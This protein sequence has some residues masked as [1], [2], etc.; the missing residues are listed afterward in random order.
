MI[1]LSHLKGQKLGVLG[2]GKSGLSTAKA[3]KKAGV[4]FIAWDDREEGR[5]ALKREVKIEAT[6]FT[7][8]AVQ[9]LDRLVLSPGIAHTY[10]EPNPAVALCKENNVRIISDVTLFLE[11]HPDNP[12]YAITGTNGKSTTTALL[13]HIFKGVGEVLVGGNIGE[14][15]LELTPPK[16]KDVPFVLE[17]SSYQLEITPNLRPRVAVLL[18]IT[19]DHLDRH[20][21]MEGYIA[22]KKMIF[23]KDDDNT[24][25]PLAVIGVDQDCTEKMEKQLRDEEGWQT[26]PISVEN[27]LDRGLYL[28]KD[29]LVEAVIED[30]LDEK[31]EHECF[32]VSRFKRLKGRHNAQNIAACYAAARYAGLDG[33]LISERIADFPGLPHRQ[34]LLRTIN[35]VSYIND[36]KATN[37]EA[38]GHALSAYNH[39]FWIL[40]G[41]AKES[42]L[43]GL[44]PFM[45]RI[46]HAF[47]IGQAEDRFSEWLE[48]YD[49][50]YTKCH[51]IQNAVPLAHSM[52]QE[53]RG[54]PGGGTVVLLSPA[55]ASWDQFRSFE[56]RGDVFTELVA[57]LE[58]EPLDSKTESRKK[59]ER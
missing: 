14:P 43:D 51:T 52:A 28:N 55:C 31:Q 16:T 57:K 2:L 56:H 8:E 33:H 12:V 3:L 4:A 17:L 59:D 58:E 40:G 41:Q 11:A 21:G 25:E 44:A 39:I 37:A 34:Y 48:Q 24:V 53:E 45:D 10:P 22:A 15:V 46:R 50:S 6:P 38:T 49:I 13:G 5:E 27:K 1:D 29:I 54:L 32:D 18:N 19:S 9:G 35:G 36:S 30:S 7:Q 20:G 23:K 42:G 26:L 47:L